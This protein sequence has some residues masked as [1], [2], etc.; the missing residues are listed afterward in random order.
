LAESSTGAAKRYLKKHISN[1]DHAVFGGHVMFWEHP[2][3][4]NRA[5]QDYLEGLAWIQDSPIA[6]P[7]I[8]HTRV[9]LRRRFQLIDATLYLRAKDGLWS[10]SLRPLPNLITL[11]SIVLSPSPPCVFV[12]ETPGGGGF[13]G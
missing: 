3:K 9:V 2:E 1:A 12:I 13:G 10:M 7:Q 8:R 6:D 11:I 4:I 5:L